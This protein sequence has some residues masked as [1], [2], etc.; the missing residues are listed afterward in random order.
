MKGPECLSV[1]DLTQFST[2]PSRRGIVGSRRLAGDARIRR[3]VHSR[4]PP[5]VHK[6][7]LPLLGPPNSSR[8][9]IPS[10]SI[11]QFKM[12]TVAAAAAAAVAA[13]APP[14][15]PGSCPNFAVVCSF[16]ERYG[17]L[18]DLPE[19]PFPELERVLQAPPPDI[20]HG[21]GKRSAR[22]PGGKRPWRALA[23]HRYL[24]ALRP[25]LSRDWAPRSP[26]SA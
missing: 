17:P 14:G 9:P 4:A 7:T 6:A 13:M 2:A 15:C 18:L 24:G 22:T 3:G 20:G 23:L 21:E 8:S 16:L 5:V 26:Y 25:A 12:A 1:P 10:S 11:L 19:L